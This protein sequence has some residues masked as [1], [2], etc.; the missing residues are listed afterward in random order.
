MPSE[1]Q[2][3]STNAAL[4]TQP[5]KPFHYTYLKEFRTQQCQEFL[6][7][8]CGNH[9]PFTCFHWH[10]L[11]QR[12]R[13]PIRR[14]DGTFN[15][16]P[17]IYCN[18]Y[19]E[20]SGVCPDG[21]DCP[22]LHRTTGDTERRYHLRYYK[23][24]T[25]VHETDAR[26]HCVK[27]GPHCA[28]AHGPHDL[29]QPVYDIREI[30]A[31]QDQQPAVV[32]EAPTNGTTGVTT[33]APPN[34]D[35]NKD[36]SVFLEDARWQES[37]FVLANYKTEPCKRPP[38]LCR[39]GYACPHYHN[40]RDR[41]RSPR[42]FRYRSTPCPNVKHGD[43][44]GEPT[45][46]EQ[47]D[48][49]PYCHTRTEQQF[50]P[51]IYKSTKCNDMQQTGYCPR[52]PF[53][54]F[55]HVD[56]EMST[57]REFSEE[58][59]SIVSPPNTP[60]TLSTVSSSP[61]TLPPHQIISSSDMTITTPSNSVP[62]PIAKPRSN[63]TSSNYSSESSHIGS[64]YQRAPGSE[65]EENTFNMF[66]GMTSITSSLTNPSSSI[67][68]MSVNATPFYPTSDT[69]ESVIGNAL[70][71]MNLDDID[72]AAFEKELD[73]DTSSVGSSGASIGQLPVG[74]YTN[75]VAMSSRIQNIFDG[76]GLG[77][78]TSA[79]V[80][81]PG[82]SSNSMTSGPFNHKSNVS[83]SPG[84]PMTN[85][86]PSFLSQQLQSQQLDHIQAAA[87][88]M[89]QPNTVMRHMGLGRILDPL[90][91]NS[92]PGSNS[93][94]GPQSPLLQGST[95]LNPVG[96]G[97]EGD[98][99]RL[100]EEI[101]NLRSKLHSWEESWNQA[102]QACDAWKK[103][104]TEAGEKSK[105]AE[106]DKQAAI[107]SKDEALI[108]SRV[109]KQEI[110]GLTGGPHLHV[111]NKVSE[112]E[113]LPLSQLKNLQ[114]QLKNDLDRLEKVI[115]TKEALRCL[116][117]M[118]RDRSVAVLPCQHLVFCETCSPTKNECPVCHIQI[119]TKVSIV[120]PL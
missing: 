17:D 52:G 117:C 71:D 37:S 16:S 49:C 32:S 4:T 6:L 80:S 62:G 46:C 22:Y 108:E 44:W 97:S 60:S 86:P 42:K 111:L 56:Q 10:F 114:V 70:D 11:N 69:V 76:L 100:Q 93:T 43:E 41:R 45:N 31:Q 109:L 101:T 28:F 48:N 98:S 34:P 107:Q 54:A 94:R 2:K 106:K 79:P 68:S 84:S 88:F 13:R 113:K 61:N 7:H 12:R 51:E 102:K 92:P 39:Q 89:S 3:P 91:T 55:A 90:G 85:L 33:T 115:H 24:G 23:T 103:E 26:G 14:R 1:Q 77:S 87:A 74:E 112:L 47:G 18:K 57:A 65:R 116:I 9:R 78:T 38:R 30:I 72:V 36:K 8:K 64:V 73:N 63:S 40:S 96:T 81:I 27:N 75:G 104:A 67:S 66:L 83:E 119:S 25:C 118:E 5:E 59:G 20:T 58:Q 50:H 82:S 21:D 19:D 53:C 99:Q 15:Y 120:V 95:N 29:R 105:Q 35:A 110:E